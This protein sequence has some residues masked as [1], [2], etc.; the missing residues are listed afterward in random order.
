MAIYDPNSQSP[1][2][3]NRT[4]PQT[5]AHNSPPFTPVHSPHHSVNS[6]VSS[7]TP[8][9][10]L[11]IHEYRKQQNT[12]SSQIVTPSGKTLRR[13]AAAPT[14]NT[15][16]LNLSAEAARS[17]SQPL[18]RPL[19]MSQSAQQLHSSHRSPFQQQ[20]LADQLGRAQSAEPR[21]QGGS[22]S[23]ISTTTSSGKVG[24]FKSRK[25]LPKPPAVTGVLSFPSHLA[26][27][28]SSPHH[29]AIH[30]AL[31]LPTRGSR[32]SD[33][34]NTH[35]TSTISLSRFPKPPHLTDPSF[36]PPHHESE[37]T[38]LDALSYASTAPATPPATPA[39][40]HY[41]G[42]SFDLVN[43]H[44]S[45]VLH[46]I[47]T[48]S[49]DFGSSEYLLIHTSE[50]PFPEFAEVSLSLRKT[51]KLLM[52]LDGTKTSAIR[53]SKCRSCWYYAT[54]RGRFQQL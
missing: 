13:K 26:N 8:I 14:L 7:R 41:R 18:L 46:D 33:T 25:R 53:R 5:L 44:D 40:I 4:P 31:D 19:H 17:N 1:R 48:P 34:R 24:H 36:S 52:F 29:P 30:T 38:R 42:A 37:R 6:S 10:T 47:V 2:V 23:S 39:T 50:E 22:I 32:S 45:L 49:K 27:A 21:A 3:P 12:P 35:T 11:S 20:L 51:F 54:R 43:P 28:K 16:R 15:S 9:H